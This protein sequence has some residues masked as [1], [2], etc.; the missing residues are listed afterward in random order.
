M[1]KPLVACR[2]FDETVELAV[3]LFVDPRKADHDG[4]RGRWHCCPARA[5]TCG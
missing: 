1:A 3:L 2:N 4:A 5:R